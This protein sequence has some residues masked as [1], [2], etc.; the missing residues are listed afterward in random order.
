MEGKMRAIHRFS[1]KHFVLAVATLLVSFG[2]M[3]SD[4][5]TITEQHTVR[6]G[7][8]THS[9]TTVYFV[10][11]NYATVDFMKFGDDG[12]LI[13]SGTID[14]PEGAVPFDI[15][16]SGD[17][18]VISDPVNGV[19]YVFQSYS[20]SAVSILIPE[21]TT[22]SVGTM[23]VTAQLNLVISA[24]AGLLVQV[25]QAALGIGAKASPNAATAHTTYTIPTPSGAAGPP[26]AL[27]FALGADGNV[28]FTETLPTDASGN[29]IVSGK[30]K[31]GRL[32]PG[33]I[34]TEYLVPTQYPGV[35]STDITTGTYIV[36]GPDGNIWFTERIAG[37]VAKI[38]PAGVITEFA[39]PTSASIYGLASGPDG[40]IWVKDYSGKIHR[41]TPSGSVTSFTIP[42]KSA[43]RDV[44]LVSGPDGALWFMEDQAIGRIAMTG[45]ITEYPLPTPAVGGTP[46]Y[47]YQLEFVENG[48]GAFTEYSGSNA[49]TLTLPASSITVATA[50]E[51]HHSAFDH[52]FITPLADEIALLDAAATPF[53]D[54]SRTGFSFNVYLAAN[55]PA[56]SVSTCRFFNDHFAPKSSHFYAPH[57]FG[58]E[59]T[60]TYFP[61]WTLE[62]PA[63]FNTMLPDA[64]G[65]CSA[66]TV[67]VYR[68]YNNGMGG[69]PNHRFV[70]SLF[71][72]QNMLNAGYVAEGNGIGVSMCVPQ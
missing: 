37:K 12:A 44:S 59:T 54:W 8:V 40:N 17:T 18:I 9:R 36:A 39:L 70:T 14:L 5:V 69:A 10:D 61:D 56:G 53:E 2:S 13:G 57:G 60:I 35:G 19:F 23:I 28:W 20:P 50:V 64:T 51:Y 30:E 43:G 41:V 67:P 68:L 21:L 47:P 29:L 62:Y 72:R 48:T 4:S 52:Y 65:A 24:G 34:I 46:N 7:R 1:C 32:S 45:A 27:N 3:A 71:E 58:C 33:G 25:Q 11:P 31:V 42:T 49:A 38:T 15:T 55:P 16:R 6:G 26:S 66:G 63:L 22:T